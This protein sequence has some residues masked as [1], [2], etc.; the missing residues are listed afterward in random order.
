MYK[1][2]PLFKEGGIYAIKDFM[3]QDNKMSFRTTENVF[4]W[5][6]IKKTNA[7]EWPFND[8]PATPYELISFPALQEQQDIDESQ[9]FDVIGK[10]EYPK[11][12]KVV[13]RKNGYSRLK[14]LVV[15]DAEGHTIVFSLWG[16]KMIDEYNSFPHQK[17][18]STIILLQ[19]CRA[20][21]YQ[22]MVYA[23][24]VHDATKMIINGDDEEFR[25]L[26]S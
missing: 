20:H 5:E 23:S 6:F 10:V 24:N 13:K 1:F 21:K 17:Y 18:D 7:F 15:T 12:E 8:F 2:E 16:D 4:K 11:P 3:V 14:E 26:R 22:G 9:A 19:L 25:D